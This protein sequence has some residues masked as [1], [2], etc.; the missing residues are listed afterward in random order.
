[1]KLTNPNIGSAPSLFGLL[2]LHPVDTSIK[3]IQEEKEEDDEEKISLQT[4]PGFI[5]YLVKNYT[6]IKLYHWNAYSYGIHKSLDKLYEE[7]GE[8][9]DTLVE[10]SQNKEKLTL[11]ICEVEIE[12]DIDFFLND[13]MQKVSDNRHI[14]PLSHT[15]S[16]IDLVVTVLSQAIYKITFLR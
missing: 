7:L 13:F 8:I 16:Q 1:M 3:H 12:D 9:I 11:K 6:L 10:S 15:Q 2:G 5:S 14:F 4:I